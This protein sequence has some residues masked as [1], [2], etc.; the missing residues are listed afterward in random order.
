MTV[1]RIIA[2]GYEIVGEP[3]V[4]HST[5]KIYPSVKEFSKSYNFSFHIIYEKLEKRKTPDEIIEFYDKKR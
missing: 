3:I 2:Q 1:V 4:V 5:K